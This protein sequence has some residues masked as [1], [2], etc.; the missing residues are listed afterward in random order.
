[1]IDMSRVANNA[2]FLGILFGFG[3]LIYMRMKG[4]QVPEKFKNVFS[5]GKL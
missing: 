3:Y 5:R 1:M 2:I 4:K